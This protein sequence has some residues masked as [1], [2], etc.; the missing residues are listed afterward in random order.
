MSYFNAEGFS[1]EAMQARAPVTF[2]KYTFKPRNEQGWPDCDRYGWWVVKDGVNVMPGACW[3]R[4]V[5]A[6]I[7]GVRRLE[8]AKGNGDLFWLL[9]GNAGTSTTVDV[10]GTAKISAKYSPYTVVAGDGEVSIANKF[11]LNPKQ[12]LALALCLIAGAEHALG[13]KV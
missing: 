2:G 4:T 13:K 7:D 9:T 12:A 3:F 6:A 11:N 8:L 5:S 10:D 1:V